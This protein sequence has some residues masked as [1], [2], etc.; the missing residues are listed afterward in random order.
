M[1][2]KQ[3][4]VPLRLMSAIR[5]AQ[6]TSS[7]AAAGLPQRIFLL[8]PASSLLKAALVSDSRSSSSTPHLLSSSSSS[9]SPDCHHHLSHHPPLLLFP[10]LP[11]S[12]SLPSRPL[13]RRLLLAASSSSSASSSFSYTDLQAPTSHLVRHP[14][15][16][17]FFLCRQHGPVRHSRFPS[18]GGQSRPKEGYRGL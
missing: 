4:P 5:C 15:Q 17:L 3:L 1:A 7:F 12:H 13:P 10:S 6:A 14:P 9:S 11:S 8:Y 2:H 16:S 18:H